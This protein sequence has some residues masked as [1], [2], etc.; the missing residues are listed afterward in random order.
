MICPSIRT[1]SLCL[2]TGD[3]PGLPEGSLERWFPELTGPLGLARFV[4]HQHLVSADEFDASIVRSWDELRSYPNE[5]FDDDYDSDDEGTA[6]P[7]ALPND[8]LDVF[9]A[10]G[11]ELRQNTDLVARGPD[12]IRPGVTLIPRLF[13]TGGRSPTAK[14]HT[15]CSPRTRKI[16]SSRGAAAR[17][18]RSRANPALGMTVPYELIQD[19]G[20]AQWDWVRWRVLAA[21]GPP[22]RGHRHARAH[23]VAHGY[24]RPGRIPRRP[25]EPR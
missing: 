23:G 21:G 19:G 3:W 17:S 10:G 14:S 7:S 9:R 25:T 6:V 1:R 5:R 13:P 4:H 8:P 24:G 2:E 15:T 22:C 20:D 12:L 18:G 11:Y 16:F